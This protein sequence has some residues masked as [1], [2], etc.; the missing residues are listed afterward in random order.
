TENTARNWGA[1]V[2]IKL[3]PPAVIE[4]GTTPTDLRRL[5]AGYAAWSRAEMVANSARACVSDAPGARRPLIRIGPGPMPRS[6]SRGPVRS[7]R[8]NAIKGTQTS[9]LPASQAPWNPGGAT[10]TIVAA[11][12]LITT[13]RPITVSAR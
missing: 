12:P 13:D 11:W 6:T 3:S 10:P 7:M 1:R 4:Y 8:E 5:V 2:E 9:V